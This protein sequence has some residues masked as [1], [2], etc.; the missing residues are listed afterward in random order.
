MNV[1][2]IVVWRWTEPEEGMSAEVWRLST[3]EWVTVYGVRNWVD[4]YWERKGSPDEVGNTIQSLFTYVTGVSQGDV[5][6][7]QTALQRVAENVRYSTGEEL[8]DEDCPYFKGAGIE[9]E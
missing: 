5:T 9:R 8:Y 2:K 4:E 6:N 1:S 3:D 7:V